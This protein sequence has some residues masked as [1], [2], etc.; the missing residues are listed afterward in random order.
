MSSNDYL[1]SETEML[2]VDDNITLISAQYLVHCLDTENVCHHISMMDHPPLEMK[3]TLFTRHIQTVLPLLAI[4]KK[5]TLQAIHTSFLNTAIDNMMDDR[6]LNNRPPP[7]NS[8]ET[9]LSR[10][11]RTPLLQLRSGHCM[12]LNTYKKLLKQTDSSSCPSSGI[13][14]Q[15]VP[16]LFNCTAHPNDLSPVSLWDKPVVTILELS[17]L[18]PGN[19]D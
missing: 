12:L 3:E 14:P 6:V 9:F 19:L 18:D 17:F 8:E 15:D 5:D 1:H 10:R 7:I 13:D 11:Q 16:H 4:T 2:Q